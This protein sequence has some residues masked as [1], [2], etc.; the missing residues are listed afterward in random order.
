MIQA[1]TATK[2]PAS[3]PSPQICS[4]RGR[5]PTEMKEGEI[6]AI[7]CESAIGLFI[8]PNQFVEPWT[9]LG[10]GLTVD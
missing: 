3:F 1:T 6:S 9:T 8:T 2:I 4:N 7:F 5:T 10:G